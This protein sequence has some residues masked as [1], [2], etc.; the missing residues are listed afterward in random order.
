MTLL[1][2]NLTTLS[3]A[4]GAAPG[5][6]AEI[7]EAID[8]PSPRFSEAGVVSAEAAPRFA[9]DL[10]DSIRRSGAVSA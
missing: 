4:D 2:G 9:A 10:A 5:S 6:F 7:G 8:W 3:D 1:P